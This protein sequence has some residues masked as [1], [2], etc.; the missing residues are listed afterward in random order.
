MEEKNKALV[1]LHWLLR[2]GLGAALLAAQFLGGRETLFTESPY[3]I[4]LGVLLLAG[5]IGL[6]AAASVHC[7]RATNAGEIATTGPYR[8]IR[9]P[10]YASVLLLCLGIGFVFFTWLHVLVLAIFAPLWWLEARCEEEEMTER[11][12]DAY[13]AYQER[14]AMLIPGLL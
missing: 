3:L 2:P 5:G 1:A 4:G 14:T 7:S 8:R 12:G 11:F 10:I 13:T 6:W 9:H